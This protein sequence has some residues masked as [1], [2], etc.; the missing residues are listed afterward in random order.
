MCM[1]IGIVKHIFTFSSSCLMT[2]A[3]LEKYGTS[4]TEIALTVVDV[5]LSNAPICW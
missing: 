5:S 3:S 1:S 2:N 4:T